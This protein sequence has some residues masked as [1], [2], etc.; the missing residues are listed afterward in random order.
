[1]GCIGLTLNIISATLL[2][3]HHGHDHGGHGHSH[4]H[5]EGT[6]HEDHGHEHSHS[7]VNV[8]AGGQVTDSSSADHDDVPL[9]VSFIHLLSLR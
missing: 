9:T 3:E 7:H 6:S 5:A 1:M 8:E 2:H 4:S